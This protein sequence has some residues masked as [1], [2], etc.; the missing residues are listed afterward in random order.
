MTNACA[1]DQL[2][3]RAE[4]VRRVWGYDVSACCV[5]RAQQILVGEWS[6][7]KQGS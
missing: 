4:R 1:L 5:L 3:A 7:R 6:K 2:T